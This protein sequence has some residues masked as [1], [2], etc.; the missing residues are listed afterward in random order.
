MHCLRLNQKHITLELVVARK[1]HRRPG[2]AMFGSSSALAPLIERTRHFTERNRTNW[3]PGFVWCVTTNSIASIVMLPQFLTRWCPPDIH[4]DLVAHKTKEVRFLV[5]QADRQ[6][7]RLLDRSAHQR[8]T[9][10][11]RAPREQLLLGVGGAVC[12]GVAG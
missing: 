1:H 11:P 6:R 5:L 4:L 12:V 9:A 2:L 3:L 8:Q 7:P 10:L